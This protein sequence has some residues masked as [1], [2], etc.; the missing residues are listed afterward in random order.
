MKKVFLLHARAQSGKD[1]CAS[2]MKEFL[3]SKSKEE[4][5][6][7]ALLAYKSRDRRFGG[8]KNETENN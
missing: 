3:E 7:R 4:E 6:D 1:T 5:F 8:V 2:I